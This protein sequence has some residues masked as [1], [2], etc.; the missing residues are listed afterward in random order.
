VK[1]HRSTGREW[2]FA[3]KLLWVAAV[4]VLAWVAWVLRELLLLAFGAI[5]VAVVLASVADMV[6]RKSR[7]SNG[8]ALAATV[9]FI[10]L[11]FGSALWLFGSELAGQTKALSAMIPSAWENLLARLEPWGFDEPLRQWL[12]DARSGAGI[13]SNMRSLAAGV[14]SATGNLILV[15]AGGIYIAAQ[16]KLYRTGLLK[17]FPAEKRGLIAEAGDE[18]AGS[19]RLWLKG[20]L[21]SMAFVGCLTT[22]G[23]WL[24]GVPSAFSLGLLSALLEFVPF[25]GPIIAAVPAMLLSLA[26]GPEM[27]MW[28]ALLYL[29][30]QQIEGNVLEPLIQ[31]R[32][33]T[34]PPALLLFAIVAAGLLFGMLGILLG[35][36]LAVFLYVLVKR[37]YVRE[38]LQTDTPLPTENQGDHEG[39]DESS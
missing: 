14:A 33:V 28:T 16:P 26:E 10:A 15:L 31:Q 9:I 12:E 36:P 21:V 38:L 37:L 30:V 3:R 7:L 17:L 8:L 23:L 4:V 2:P 27:A 18:A 25:L 35:G 22:L 32:A 24:I 29:F 6:A 20:R 1:E 34:I 13:V 19:L 11:L 5:L 39:P